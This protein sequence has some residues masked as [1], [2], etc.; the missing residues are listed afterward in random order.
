MF[1]RAESGAYLHS[2]HAIRCCFEYLLACR[3]GILA[4]FPLGYLLYKSV[5]SNW[6]KDFFAELQLR[7]I[8]EADI[9]VV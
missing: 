1:I 8:S 3:N 4:F 9:A 7:C 5:I 2:S 6:L